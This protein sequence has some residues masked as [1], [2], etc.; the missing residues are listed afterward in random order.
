MDKKKAAEIYRKA[1]K[2]IQDVGWCQGL[3]FSPEG[4]CCA[5]GALMIASGHDPKNGLACEMPPAYW[6][7]RDVAW[8]EERQAL[9]QRMSTNPKHIG[10][11]A[12]AGYNDE[13]ATSPQEVIGLL[14]EIATSL[15]KA[16]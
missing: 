7:A 3:F 4:G 13:H 10:R 16:A 2:T 15:E 12:L 6:E 9:M 11:G 8:D 1:A 5:T 14:N